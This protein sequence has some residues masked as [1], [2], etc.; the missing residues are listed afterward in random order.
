[1]VDKV[2]GGPSIFYIDLLF[3]L[4]MFL[5]KIVLSEV[6]SVLCVL[7]WSRAVNSIERFVDSPSSIRFG[8]VSKL[9]FIGTTGALPPVTRETVPADVELRS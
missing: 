1:M 9:L 2:D 4:S 5:G 6:S 8:G 7:A 3:D